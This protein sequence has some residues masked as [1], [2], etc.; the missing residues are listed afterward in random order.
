MSAPAGAPPDVGAKRTP[1]AQPANP[2]KTRAEVVE[3]D[4][5]AVAGGQS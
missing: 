3:P 1:A 5:A 4:F 2:A